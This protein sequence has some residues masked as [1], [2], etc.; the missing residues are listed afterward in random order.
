MLKEVLEEFV[1]NLDVSFVDVAIDKLEEAVQDLEPHI[2][3]E[4]LV[5]NIIR[6]YNMTTSDVVKELQIETL[7][8][9]LLKL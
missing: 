9:V 8:Q 3:V 1:V 2:R 4:G 6:T 7:K 5:L